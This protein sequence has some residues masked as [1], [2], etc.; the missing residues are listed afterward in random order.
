MDMIDHIEFE[1][2]EKGVGY[3]GRL[4]FETVD[5]LKSYLS[6]HK[7]EDSSCVYEYWTTGGYQAVILGRYKSKF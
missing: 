5:D 4:R 3:N 2:F 1:P 6:Q 7:C